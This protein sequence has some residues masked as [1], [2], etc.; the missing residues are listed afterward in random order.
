MRC[1][2]VVAVLFA[3]VLAPSLASAQ[4]TRFRL[5]DLDLRDPHIFA[6]IIGCNDITDSSPFFSLNTRL[7][8]AIQT[9]GDGDGFLDQSTLLEFLPLDQSVATNLFDAGGAQC[10]S[11]IASTSCGAIAVPLLPGDATLS[12]STTCA[13]PVPGT[14]RP[15]TPAITN[16]TAPCFASVTGNVTLNLGGIPVQLTNAQI[17][18]TFVGNPA[19]SMANGLLRGFLSEADANA[20]IIPATF[21]LVGGQPLSSLLPGGTGNC[22]AF[23]DKDVGP[24]GVAGWY[25]YLNFPAQKLDEDTFTAGFADGFE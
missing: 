25:F 10:T 15:Y 14:T 18:A 11:P 5:N 24:G 19:T 20:T 1:R 16:S 4:G 9:D 6:A 13:A 2:Q 7:Q 21:P 22:A 23:S 17:S 8:T 3:L 12:T